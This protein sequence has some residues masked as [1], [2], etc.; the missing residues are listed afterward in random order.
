MTLSCP[1]YITLG[2][3]TKK[4]PLLV[5]P[6]LLAYF[7]CVSVCVSPPPLLLGNGLWLHKHIPA[8]TNSHAIIE[9]LDALFFMQSMLH[10]RKVGD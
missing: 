7:P 2:H 8:A 1:P 6:L 9:L 3:T 10:Q 5:I 4:T